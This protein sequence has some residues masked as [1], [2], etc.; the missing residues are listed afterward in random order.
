MRAGHE[1]LD[2]DRQHHIHDPWIEL[3]PAAALDLGE[4]L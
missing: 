4:R 2:R 1:V 3:L